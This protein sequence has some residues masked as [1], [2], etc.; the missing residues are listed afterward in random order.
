MGPPAGARLCILAFLL[1]HACWGFQSE[2]YLKWYSSISSSSSSSSSSSAVEVS[3]DWTLPDAGIFK[4]TYVV[5]CPSNCLDHAHC[6]NVKGSGPYTVHSPICLSAIHAGVIGNKGGGVSVT[7]SK[8]TGP[9]M[10]SLKN[11][12]V[13]IS[14]ESDFGAIS[15]EKADV[16]C[17]PPT[18]TPGSCV[19]CGSALVDLV[20]VV[21]S[22]VSVGKDDFKR[23]IEF[24]KDLVNLFS[25]SKSATRVGLITF[26]SYPTTP[27][28]LNRYTTKDDVM[29]A[30][31]SVTYRQ[32]GTYIGKAL[33]R[34]VKDMIF[35]SDPDVE[36]IVVVMSDGRSFDSV[37]KPVSLLS[38][39]KVSL[40]SLGIGRS[41]QLGAKTLLEIANGVKENYYSIESYADL[42][43]YLASITE[44]LAYIIRCPYT[45]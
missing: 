17:N 34:V 43:N 22:S 15:L 20:F 10:G 39:K 27:F 16:S 28:K 7:V 8:P 36:K 3:C 40:L 44:R 42:K 1:F 31:D 45:S 5:V 33:Y 18:P 32:G 38:T 26:N 12:V 9:F 6:A 11:S 25:I 24:V 4:K 21:D 29:K 13:S 30:L 35:R 19:C 37:T 14:E 41:R 23:G 2:D